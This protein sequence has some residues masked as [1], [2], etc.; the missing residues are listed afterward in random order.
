MATVSATPIQSLEGR[1][2]PRLTRQPAPD[3]LEGL[4][5]T[6]ARVSGARVAASH[7]L[8]ACRARGTLTTSRTA[9]CWRS[10]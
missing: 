1:F 5:P 8:T 9:R 2:G 10:A 3:D 6:L 4:T 7:I